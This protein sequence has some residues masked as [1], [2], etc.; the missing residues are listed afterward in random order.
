[1]KG[2][3]KKYK[4]WI[5]GL[6]FVLVVAGA[7][8]FIA[9]PL[10]ARIVA[11]SDEIQKKAIDNQINQAR[12]AKIPEMKAQHELFASEAERL[13][14]VVDAGSEVDF[15]KRLELLAE[16]TGNKIDLKIDEEAAT[17]KGAKA[18]AKKES[19]DTTVTEK[20]AS[21]SATKAKKDLEDIKANLPS[22]FYLMLH[23]N[24]EGNYA[25]FMNFLRQ[26]EN[27]NYYANVVSLNLV[28]A[29]KQEEERSGSRDIFSSNPG[30]FDDSERQSSKNILK[31]T[32]DVAVYIKK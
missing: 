2:F 25:G 30:D 27:F 19:S 32:I 8:V 6:L 4:S 28:K 20:D 31:S 17:Q 22:A 23:I 13:N 24:L 9:K 29:E 1:M 10:V 7:I 16:E 12:I 26:L 15:I 3:W 21:G 18:V 5:S 11:I 14:V